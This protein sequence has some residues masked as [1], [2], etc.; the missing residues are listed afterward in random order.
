MQ[1]W[2]DGTL[3]KEINKT[4]IVLIPKKK[5]A[6]RVEDWR[7]ISLCMVAIKIITKIIAQRLQPILNQVISTSQSAFVKSCIIIDNFVVAH[8]IANFLKNCRDDG[9]YY[10]SV[11]VDMSKAYD[12]VEWIFL[13]KLLLRLGFVADWVGRVMKCVSTVS[14]QLRVNEKISNIIVPS[15]GLRQGQMVNFEKSEICFSR[16]T[17]ANVRVNICEVLRVPQVKSH[18]RYLGLPLIVGQK[19]SVVFSD[20][21]EKIWKKVKDWKHKFLSADGREE[22]G[23]GISW[24]KQDILQKKKVEGGLGLKD[25]A[26]FNEAMLL[27]IAWRIV[28]F[29]G[30]LMSRLLLAKYC[31]G[32]NFFEARLGNNPSHIWR[33][34]MISLRIFLEGLVG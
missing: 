1:F 19:M 18:S 17:P 15:R 4:M 30:L 20:I 21:V 2:T 24:I 9:N 12:R 29:P 11:K 25:L 14:Y 31:M 16:N 28:E 26:V 5:D 23:R 22:G 7:P 6:L 32:G 34:V 33:G 10:A 13:E 27:K 8:E 3:D